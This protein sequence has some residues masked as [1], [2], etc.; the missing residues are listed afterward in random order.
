MIVSG[1]SARQVTQEG[2]CLFIWLWFEVTTPAPPPL[3]FE[4]VRTRW[5]DSGVLSNHLK[6]QKKNK[7]QNKNKNKNKK[8]SCNRLH[9][10]HDYVVTQF[11]FL[12]FFCNDHHLALRLINTIVYVITNQL[13]RVSK[14]YL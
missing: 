11:F 6:K 4:S 12:S 7:K 8:Q 3:T 1:S 10:Y 2:W 14:T 9:I 5:R 13:D